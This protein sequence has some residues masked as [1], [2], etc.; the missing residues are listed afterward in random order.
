MLHSLRPFRPVGLAAAA[1]L[2]FACGG[3][4]G[5]Q[6]ASPPVAIGGTVT[7]LLVGRT[8]VLQNNGSDDATVSGNGSFTFSVQVASGAAYAVTIRTQ[9]AGETCAVTGGTGSVTA[10]G[11][12]N[13]AVNCTANPYHIGGIVAGLVGAIVLQDN[14]GDNLTLTSAGPFTFATQVAAGS[15]YAVRVLTQ[16]TGLQCSVAS[17]AGVVASSDVTSIVVTCLAQ[18]WAWQGGSGSTNVAGVYGASGTATASNMPGARQAANA[19][20]G[21]G[22]NVSMF[23]GQ[24]YDA[25]G[26][27]GQLSDLWTYC[28]CAGQR[29]WAWIGGSKVAN[30]PGVYGSQGT[31]AV[32]NGPGG[33]HG[34][35][36][37]TDAYG[38]LWLLAGNG[39]DSAGT[40]DLLNDLWKYTPSVGTW[41]WIS[42]SS[43]VRAAGV[44]G[45]LGTPAA[46]NS[47]GARQG[48][49]ALA[50]PAGSLWLFGGQGYDAAGT[51]GSLNDLWEFSTSNGTWRWT[52]G[53]SAVNG[54]GVYG[55]LGTGSTGT[56]PGARQDAAS[57]IDSSG[58]L[59]LFGGQGYDASG[60]LGDLND[61]WMYTPSSG[62]WTWIG[63]SMQANGPGVYGIQGVVS[64][65][66]TPGARHGA[67]AWVDAA[68]ALWLFGGRGA[69]STGTQGDLN[70]LWR[71]DPASSAWRWTGGASVVNTAGQYGLLGAVS[72]TNAPG[73]RAFGQGWVDPDGK[74]WLFGG[75]GEGATATGALNDIWQ[76]TP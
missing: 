41:A 76:Y 33:R 55:S 39:V 31:A 51:R 19:W 64:P 63:G 34:A 15:A 72:A 53:S 62:I 2:L 58:R 40:Q 49:S 45:T 70:D 46:S 75:Y 12:S 68:G 36:S 73:A 48:A 8:I 29:L 14:G 57:W 5:G 32:G 16:P 44:Y 50:D 30:A 26:N 47:P 65:G 71:F 20:V 11:I 10:G 21:A 35:A 37:W 43:L 23:G 52:S 25:A 60:V 17:G 3:G 66:T 59:W 69:D 22:G 74:L 9:P 38:N 6:A 1:G 61:L 4:G 18:V 42:G 67:T 13:V 54:S 27:S 7:G 56:A 28:E 24:G